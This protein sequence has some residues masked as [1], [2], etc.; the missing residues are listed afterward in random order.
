MNKDNLKIKLP[1]GSKGKYKVHDVLHYSD[2]N[3]PRVLTLI[4][5]ISADAEGYLVR[6]YTSR[7]ENDEIILDYELEAYTFLSHESAV[8]FANRL[9][10]LTVL[11]LLM[12][13][14]GYDFESMQEVSDILQ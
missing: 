7:Q 4:H 8:S 6:M 5:D 10:T 12:I 14:S 2:R 9:P 3:G 13:Q 11:E 1:E